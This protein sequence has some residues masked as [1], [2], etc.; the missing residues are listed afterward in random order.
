MN[1]ISIDVAHLDK[2]SLEYSVICSV[3]E[4]WDPSLKTSVKDE[5]CFAHSSLSWVSSFVMTH[6]I[7]SMRLEAPFSYTRVIIV[8]FVTEEAAWFSEV[9]IKLVVTDNLCTLFVQWADQALTLK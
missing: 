2:G 3:K 5:Y 1:V 9:M 7:I 6:G 4:C 8:P